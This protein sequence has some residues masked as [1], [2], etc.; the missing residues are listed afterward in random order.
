MTVE[1]DSTDTTPKESAV[2]SRKYIE[3]QLHLKV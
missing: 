2:V 3:E 1:L